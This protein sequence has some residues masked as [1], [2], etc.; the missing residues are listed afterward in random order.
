MKYTIHQNP[1]RL[2]LKLHSKVPAFSHKAFFT[3]QQPIF[4][5]LSRD[6]LLA[7]GTILS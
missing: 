2:Q 7:G 1:R 3:K 6:L 4:L 5:N